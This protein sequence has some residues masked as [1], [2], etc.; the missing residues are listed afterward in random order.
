M[1]KEANAGELRTRVRFTRI[2]RVTDADGFKTET[3]V[4]VFTWPVM[5]KWVNVHG[6]EVYSAMQMNL[7]EPATVTMRYSPLVKR[8]Q[9]IYREDDPDPYEIISLDNVENRREWLE[10]KVQRLEGAR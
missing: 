9:L 10:L 4:D 7:R 3:S 5:V 2:E 6:L 1:S 8:D